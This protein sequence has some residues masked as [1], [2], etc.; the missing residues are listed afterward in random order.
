MDDKKGCVKKPDPSTCQICDGTQ[1]EC[2]ESVETLKLA[3]DDVDGYSTCDGDCD[4]TRSAIHPGATESCGD[5]TDDDCDGIIDEG[6]EDE[7]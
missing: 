4:D 7:Q 5:G 6:D 2:D 1:G 3:D